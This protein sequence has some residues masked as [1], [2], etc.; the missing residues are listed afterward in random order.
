MMNLDHRSM[1]HFS[2]KGIRAL[3]SILKERD[4]ASAALAGVFEGFGI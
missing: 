3:H 2:V 1:P 4:A